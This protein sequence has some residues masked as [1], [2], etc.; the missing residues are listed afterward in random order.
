MIWL[1]NKNSFNYVR[2]KVETLINATPTSPQILEFDFIADNPESNFCF[3]KEICPF[4]RVASP[5]A[6]SK[7]SL[8]F[9]LKITFMEDNFTFE[10]LRWFSVLIL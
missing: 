5:E 2:K 7:M 10:I 3:F 4:D 9:S 1:K 6:T 8:Y